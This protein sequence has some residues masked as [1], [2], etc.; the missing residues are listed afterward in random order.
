MMVIK[1]NVILITSPELADFRRRLKNL[2]TKVGSL[3]AWELWGARLTLQGWTD[4]VFV[5]VPIL[6]SQ[7]RGRVCPL[8]LGASLR[9]CLKPPADL[10]RHP[11]SFPAAPN[12]DA[13]VAP[14]S[15]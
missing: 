15:S 14:I 1:L 6:V 5:P 13:S 4:A 8:S 3:A 11:A 7:S 12:A 2:E 10:V 9:T